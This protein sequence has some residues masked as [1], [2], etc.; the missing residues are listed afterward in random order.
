[1]SKG[2]GGH[3]ISYE[4]MVAKTDRKCVDDEIDALAA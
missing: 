3:H 2:Q 1:M 4:G